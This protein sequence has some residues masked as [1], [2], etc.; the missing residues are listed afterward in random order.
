MIGAIAQDQQ[1]FP[2]LLRPAY[3]AVVYF[4]K[5]NASRRLR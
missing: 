4:D 5:T 2:T 1:F 3:D